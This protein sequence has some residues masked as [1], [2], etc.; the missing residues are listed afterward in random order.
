M[1]YIVR[2][3]ES[4]LSF[5]N[6]LANNVDFEQKKKRTKEE[7]KQDTLVEFSPVATREIASKKHRPRL[8]II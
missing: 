4:V 8:W 2:I 5:I 1:I 3:N 7:K 6:V